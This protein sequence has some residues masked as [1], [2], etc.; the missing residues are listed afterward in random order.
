MELAIA[1]GIAPSVW[2]V[3]PLAVV[4]TAIDVIRQRGG[5]Q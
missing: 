3:E 5:T 4:A 1:T 2:A